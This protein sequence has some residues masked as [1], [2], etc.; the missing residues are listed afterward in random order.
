MV[1]LCQKKKSPSTLQTV[2]AGQGLREQTV[3]DGFWL[4]K[5]QLSKCMYCLVG[6]EFWLSILKTLPV[7]I[8]IKLKV[9]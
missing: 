9:G 6:W 2:S 7:H 5:I 8:C 1:L 3:S 4:L